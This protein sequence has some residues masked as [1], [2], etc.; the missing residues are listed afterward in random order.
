MDE[1]KKLKVPQLKDLLKSEGLPITG[2]KDDLIKRLFDHQ[3]ETKTSKPK[4]PSPSPNNDAQEPS[5][6]DAQVADLPPAKDPQDPLTNNVQNPSTNTVQDPPTEDGQHSSTENGQHPSTEI[7]QNSSTE[8]E[9][10]SSTQNG[11]HPSTTDDQDDLPP[12]KRPRLSNETVPPQ[13]NQ[14]EMDLDLEPDPN[15]PIQTNSNRTKSDLYLDTINRDML[16]FDFER[17]CSVTL[18]NINIYACLVCGKYFQGRSKIS[19]AYAHSIG[20][21]HHVFIN[22]SSEKVYVLPDGYEVSDP[23]LDDIKYLLNP[24]FTP[25]FLNR[26]DTGLYPIAYDLQGMSYLPGFVGLNNIKANDYLNVIVQILSHVTPLRDYLICRK[27]TTK[28]TELVKRFGTLMR[29]L[30]NPKAFKSQVSPHE[31]GQE[32]SKRSNGRFRLTE[33]A[34]PLEFLGWLLNTLHLD[35][36]GSK[37]KSIKK[38]KIKLTAGKDQDLEMKNEDQEDEASSII[39]AAFRGEVRVEEHDILARPDTGEKGLKPIFDLGAEVRTIQTPFLFLTIDLPP[40][41]VF[42]DSIEK[43]IIPQ[44]G[45]NEVLMKYDGNR[46]IELNG[47]LK[48]FK[49][50]DLPPFLILHFKRFTSNNFIEEKNPTIVNF[51][52]KGID[53]SPYYESKKLKEKDQPLETLYDLLANVTYSSTAGTAKEDSQ[54]KVQVHTRS[55]NAKQEEE[56]KANSLKPNEE[57]WFQIQDLIVEEINRQ[58]VFLGESYIQVWERRSV[59]S[60]LKFKHSLK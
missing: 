54:W 17:L 57:K 2:K 36:G 23:S 14:D 45:L 3:S 22:L 43:N 4:S 56:L 27:P 33:Q 49:I 21:D 1:L 34:D 40:P 48:R 9:Q 59:G 28:D 11:Q 37:K 15:P 55:V 30:W 58:M 46:T 29:K 53:L 44:I 12:T 8:I 7:E 6:D 38:K 25:E 52:T 13:I 32:V 35:L 50:L 19:P 39:D 47:K 16:D 24:T 51:H 60:T 41:P 10:H 18:S 5:N 20:S 42:Q 31:F 26:L